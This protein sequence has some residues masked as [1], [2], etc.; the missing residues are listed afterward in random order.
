MATSHS[1]LR[2][3]V[4]GGASDS[5]TWNLVFLQL[6]LE[7]GGHQVVNLGPCVPERLLTEQCRALDPDLLVIG[8]VNGHGYH[9]GERAALAL[10]ADPD[11]AG[12]PAVI[13]G[14]LG[15]SGEQDETRRARLLDAGFDAVFDDGDLDA[16]L[17]FVDGL[18]SDSTAGSRADSHADGSARGAAA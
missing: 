18:R 4:A 17:H 5:H 2:V 3:L 14:K 11:L 1:G 6:L 8:S 9:D 15:V 13:G 16:F 12:L 7:E 10:R